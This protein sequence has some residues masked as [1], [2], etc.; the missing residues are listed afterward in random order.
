VRLSEVACL[1]ILM[2]GTAS[3]A[4]AIRASWYRTGFGRISRRRLGVRS[5]ESIISR[6]PAFSAVELYVTPKHLFS[7]RGKVR[8]DADLGRLRALA[9][10]CH[11]ILW[12]DAVEVSSTKSGAQGRNDQT[13]VHGRPMTADGRDGDGHAPRTGNPG[14]LHCLFKNLEDLWRTISLAK[15]RLLYLARPVRRSWPTLLQISAQ[16]V[17]MPQRSPIRGRL[18][19]LQKSPFVLGL[20]LILAG[21]WLLLSLYALTD[22]GVSLSVGGGCSAP[23]RAGTVTTDAWRIWLDSHRLFCR[24]HSPRR[25][26]EHPEIPVQGDSN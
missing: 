26:A 24:S 18:R 2:I 1:A 8:S 12:N 15:Y 10:S 22:I 9:S 4:I 5:V 11:R 13:R 25:V 7:M 14:R 17:L 19:I 6:D 3:A 21:L 16:G 20:L 23:P